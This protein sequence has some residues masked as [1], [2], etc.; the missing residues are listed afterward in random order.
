MRNSFTRLAFTILLGSCADEVD[1][2]LPVAQIGPPLYEVDFSCRCNGLTLHRDGR[3]LQV[4]A[5]QWD[6]PFAGSE[7]A[8]MSEATEAELDALLDVD[9]LGK[10]ARGVPHDGVAVRLILAGLTLTYTQGHPPS[11]LVELDALLY[12]LTMDIATCS[13]SSRLTVAP[14]CEILTEYPGE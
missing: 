7:I 10:P 1:E 8:T 9:E 11:A 14:D 13:D 3:D 2:P 5:H 12:A 4:R 6:G